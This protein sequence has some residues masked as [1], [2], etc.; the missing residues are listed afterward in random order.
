MQARFYA[1]W[2]GRFLSPDPARDQHFEETQSWNIYSY[3]QNN[4][5]M[6]IDPDGM[7]MT[8]PVSLGID[9][10]IKLATWLGVR[11]ANKPA[12]PPVSEEAKKDAGA[13]FI[14]DVTN[15]MEASLM[16]V[17]LTEELMT[18]AGGEGTSGVKTEETT[19][20]RVAGREAVIGEKVE[21]EMVQR[22]MSTAELKATQETGLIRGGRA[23]EH[24]VTDSAN[25][26]AQRAQQRLALPTKPEVKATLEVP[27]G[28][29][30]PPSTVKP[31]NGMPGGGKERTAT[32][33]VPAKVRKVE[34]LRK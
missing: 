11:E 16:F 23:G 8:D 3:V 15:G 32:G 2:F 19:S 12:A 10:G 1:P 30:S 17:G 27:K 28:K 24:F 20:A 9:L 13:A 25:S 6:K 34:E 5:T 18:P 33:N 21:T 31:A 29:F 26:S 7:R 14:R 4:P 22:V